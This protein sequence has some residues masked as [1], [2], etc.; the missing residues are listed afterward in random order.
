MRRRKLTARK[1]SGEHLYWY[2]AIQIGGTR[3]RR[4]RN[5]TVQADCPIAE[6]DLCCVTCNSRNVQGTPITGSAWIRC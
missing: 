2:A 4:K 3:T 1:F 5:S 6:K